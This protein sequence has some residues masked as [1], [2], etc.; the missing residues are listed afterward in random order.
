MKV[1]PATARHRLAHAGK[2]FYFCCAACLEK[3]RAQPDTYRGS[4]KHAPGPSATLV[5]LGTATISS[6]RNPMRSKTGDPPRAA[7]V[8]P[9]CPQVHQANP[10]P[11]PSCGMALESDVPVTNTRTE[12]TCPMHPEIIRQEP[13][14]CPICVMA[15]EPR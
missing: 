12:Y 3:F 11:C 2:D 8:C 14:A 1:N 5:T 6:I 15:L 10:G 7:Y 13:G 4:Q 9:M